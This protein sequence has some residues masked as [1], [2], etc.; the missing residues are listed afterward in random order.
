MSNAEIDSALSIWAKAHG[1]HVQRGCS[2]LTRH[3][4]HV[5]ST[6]GE[7][8]QVV[9]QPEH[10][11]SVRVDVYLIEGWENEENFHEVH[12]VPIA[13]LEKLLDQILAQMEV[14]FSQ[15]GRG[16][17]RYISPLVDTP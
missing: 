1:I 5:P 15:K 2:D 11:K 3:V 4:F 7:V 6:K 8:F 14:W 9:V 12:E 17:T 16:G 10:E 13:G